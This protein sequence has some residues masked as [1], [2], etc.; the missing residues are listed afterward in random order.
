M[1]TER[2]DIVINE[3]GSRRV[4]RNI[5]E[6]GSDARR[7]HGGVSLL[8]TA[9]LGIGGT[10]VVRQLAQLADAY[11]NIQNR[12]RVVTTGTGELVAVTESLFGISNRTR[13][14]FEATAQIY[15]RLAAASQDLGSSQQELLNFTESLNQAVTI[16]GATAEEAQGALV[17]LSQGIASTEL[18]G[19]ELRSVLEQ[20]PFVA[21]VIADHFDV[22][23]GSLIKLGEQAR[24]RRV[25]FLKRFGMHV[26][27]SGNVLPGSSRRFHN[28]LWS[29]ET[30]L[31][32]ISA[33]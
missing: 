14:E 20:L 29:L 32:G 4:R 11:T 22:A 17:Q 3:R 18:R 2:I 7:A 16:S 10:L 25:Q 9:L 8:Q 27:K 15:Q 28:R 23:R 30:T 5:R 24:F 31:W 6:I 19:Q 12:L 1:P 33:G 21:Q 13:V 26:R